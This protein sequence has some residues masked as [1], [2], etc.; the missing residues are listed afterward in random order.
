MAE[1]VARYSRWLMFVTILGT[2]AALGAWWY[3]SQADVTV[4]VDGETVSLRTRADTVGEV[5][6]AEEIT[7]DSHDRVSPPLEAAVDDGTTIRVERARAISVDLNGAMRTV[8]TTGETVSDVLDELGLDADVIEPDPDTPVRDGA[9]LVLR[10]AHEVVVVADGDEKTLLTTALTVGELLDEMG[11]GLDADDEVSPSLAAT[12]DDGLTVEV[13]RVATDLAVEERAIP[14]STERRDDPS[15][16]RG[17]VHT[18]QEGSTGIERIEYRLTRRDGEVVDREIVSRSVIREPVSRV[19][20]VGTKPVSYQ[21]GR[22]SW[23]SAGSMTCAHRSLPMGTRVTVVNTANGR[24]IVC[25]VADRG[26][27]VSGRIIDL[28]HDAFSQLADPSVGVINVRI[29]W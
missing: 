14:F 20:A 28:A 5:L 6:R 8:W 1:R 3:T 25:R 21:T 23:Y 16:P 27:F 18:I 9:Q 11:I 13:T 24:S 22:A 15:L 12:V 7:L 2:I 4:R 10:S 19:V 26:P 17:E 29:S